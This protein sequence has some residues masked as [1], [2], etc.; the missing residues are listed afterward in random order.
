MGPKPGL[1][2]VNFNKGTKIRN[3][4]M[5]IMQWGREKIKK[6]KERNNTAKLK[7]RAQMRGEDTKT[8]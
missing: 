1:P 6:V 4:T 8:H 7:K 5:I 2:K 3:A